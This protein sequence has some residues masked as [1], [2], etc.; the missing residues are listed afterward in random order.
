MGTNETPLRIEDLTFR[1]SAMKI[2]NSLFICL[3]GIYVD[4]AKIRKGDKLT[5]SIQSDGSLRVLSGVS[6]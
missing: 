3:P 2:G 6:R 4:L 5:L 1:R